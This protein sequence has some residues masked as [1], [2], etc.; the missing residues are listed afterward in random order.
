MPSPYSEAE[1]EQYYDHE[2]A[3]YRA[4]WDK[5]GS[6]HWG[7]FEDGANMTFL[8]AGANLNK[9]MAQR[10]G[11]DPAADVIDVGCGSGTTAVALCKEYGCR[12]TGVDLSGVRIANAIDSLDEQPASVRE[13]LDFKKGSATELPIN[14]ESFTH[15]WSQATI[16]H[17]PDKI[18][19]LEEVYRVLKPGG[20]FV[21]D[22]LIKPQP[23]ISEKARKFVYDRLLYDTDFS[24]ESYQEALRA[25]GFTVQVA[26]DISR[27][28]KTSYLMLSDAASRGNEEHRE[29]F[30]FLAEAYRETAAAVDNKEL[31]WAMFVCRK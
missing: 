5:D 13:K 27:H 9:V 17:V 3:V 16:Y 29:R 12:V 30:A 22:D 8:E 10:G 31:G 26:D 4:L 21:F 20:I 15:A 25:A 7:L 1:T 6:V 11:L 14:D 28:L 19:V 2:D 18:K 23:N 24:F